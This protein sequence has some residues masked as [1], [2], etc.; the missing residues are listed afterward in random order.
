MTRI[1][2]PEFVARAAKLG[3]SQRQV[4]EACGVSQPAIT[5]FKARHSITFKP[6]AKTG[7][8]PMPE[9]KDVAAIVAAYDAREAECGGFENADV[10]M[11]ITLAAVDCGMSYPTAA[12]ALREHWARYM[13][14]G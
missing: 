4:A 6:P 10:E 11:C 3:L 8:R 2:C 7:Y 13:R 1:L 14:A 9:P 12:A 5:L